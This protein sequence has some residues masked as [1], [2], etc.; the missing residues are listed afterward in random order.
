MKFLHFKIQ[1]SQWHSMLQNYRTCSWKDKLPPTPCQGRIIIEIFLF[2]SELL[3]YL[4]DRGPKQH[5]TKFR[6]EHTQKICKKHPEQWTGM[7]L[8]D[9]YGKHTAH[10]TANSNHTSPCQSWLLKP[11]NK[12]QHFYFYAIT[13]CFWKN[14]AWRGVAFSFCF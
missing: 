10:H 7:L 6:R 11:T 9:K 1:C 2:C 13:K 4:E 12:A 14:S 5:V 3:L 8:A